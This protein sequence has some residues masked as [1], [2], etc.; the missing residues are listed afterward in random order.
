VSQK[1]LDGADVASVLDRN[2]LGS[3]IVKIPG[4]PVPVA[5]K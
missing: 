3:V 4:I 5:K 2:H 1:L